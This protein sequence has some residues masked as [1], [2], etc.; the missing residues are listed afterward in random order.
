[1]RRL[2]GKLLL[3]THNQGK[4]REFQDLLAPYGVTLLSAAEANV[5]EPEETGKTFAENALLKA[6]HAAAASG[7]PAL[8]D[9]SGLSVAALSGAPGI[10]SARWAGANKDFNAAMKKVEEAL[11]EIDAE[12]YSAEFVCCLALAW[13]EEKKKIPGRENTE[14]FEGRIKGRLIFPPRGDKGFGY[15]PIFIPESYHETF[16]EMNPEIKHAISHRA[17]AFAQ[18]VRACFQDAA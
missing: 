7:L 12:D 17:R 4:T 9:D 3:A 13:P 5:P 18:F 16:G 14:I 8:A 1:M 6:R 2:N 10:Y 15:D 11:K